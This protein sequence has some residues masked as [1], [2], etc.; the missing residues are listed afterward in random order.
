VGDRVTIPAARLFH[1]GAT[2]A[3]TGGVRFDP[4]RDRRG[5]VLYGP[6]LPLEPGRFRVALRYRGGPVTGSRMVVECPED[7]PL[8]SAGAIGEGRMEA[9]VEIPSSLPVNVIFSYDDE[10]QVQIDALEIERIRD[11]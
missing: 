2:D 5:A 4:V 11:L 10:S 1:A 3:G 9:V 8:T 7:H 6:K